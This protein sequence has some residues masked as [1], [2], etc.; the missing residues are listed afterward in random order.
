MLTMDAFRSDAFSAVSLTGAVDKMS[1]TPQLLGSVPGLFVDTPVR[2]P[3]IWIEERANAPALIQTTPRSAPPKVRGAEQRDA[4]SFIAKAIGEGSRI[5]ADELLGIRAFGS[6]TEEKT[7]MSEIAR[8]QFLI[9]ADHDL[10]LENWRLSVVTQAKLLDADGSMIYDWGAEFGQST[11]APGGTDNPIVNWDL[12]NASP[13]SGAVRQLCNQTGRY[14]KRALRGVGGVSVQIYAMCGDQFWDALTMH[15]EVRQTY[16]NWPDAAKL[17]DDVGQIWD[18][19][20][21]GSIL[22]F[23]YRSTDDAQPA[24]GGVTGTEATPSV[25]V[26]STHASFFPSNAGIFQ[27]AYA[28]PPKF[29]FLGTPGLKRYSWIVLD[30][31]RD[32]WADVETFAYPLAVCTMPQALVTAKR[33]STDS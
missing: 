2:T 31:K 8:R 12:L 6:E 3:A 20:R 27:M 21:Y 19:F 26:P 23:N 10:T 14:I 25:G 9:G 30:E 33:T 13:A 24:S 1:F 15:P 32:Q 16:I 29:E 4:R 5:T 7:L 17:R 18:S 11:L 22:W 28:P